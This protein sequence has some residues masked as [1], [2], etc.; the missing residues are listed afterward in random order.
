MLSHVYGAQ[1][2]YSLRR[3]QLLLRCAARAAFHTVQAALRRHPEE[4]V[5]VRQEILTAR[6]DAAPNVAAV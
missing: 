4:F 2:N 5:A 3:Q 1:T 6:S